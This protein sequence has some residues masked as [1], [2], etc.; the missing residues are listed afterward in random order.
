MDR[1]NS[2]GGAG[3]NNA[4]LDDSWDPQIIAEGGQPAASSGGGGGT[5]RHIT[6]TAGGD[7]PSA[8]QTAAA[9]AAL[10]AASGGP[11]APS[12][13]VGVEVS[14]THESK[15]DNSLLSVAT[16]SAEEAAAAEQAMKR[17]ARS[18]LLAC[19]DEASV[20]LREKM[21]CE[22][23]E[24]RQ[25]SPL[26]RSH[27]GDD[28]DVTSLTPSQKQKQQKQQQQI[29]GR[30]VNVGGQTAV[31][32]TKS[33]NP[34]STKGV[35]GIIE[36]SEEMADEPSPHSARKKQ[37]FFSQ[38]DVNDVKSGTED[39][40]DEQR[41]QSPG[42]TVGSRAAAVSD[43][44]S[45]FSYERQTQEEMPEDEF[46]ESVASPPQ[47]Q[48]SSPTGRR[49]DSSIEAEAA[50]REEEEEGIVA[51]MFKTMSDMCNVDGGSKTKAAAVGG[52]A[53]VGVG[54]AA[55]AA[56]STSKDRTTDESE[57]GLMTD[58]EGGLDV[59]ICSYLQNICGTPVAADDEA[60]PPPPPFMAAVSASSSRESYD[61]RAA[62][63]D[64]SPTRSA[65]Q[66][67]NTAIEVE[68]VDPDYYSS[69]EEDAGGA[70]RHRS[71]DDDA[72]R[73]APQEEAQGPRSW[74]GWQ[75]S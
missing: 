44:D 27:G 13:D 31:T 23:F 4:A 54:A 33:L 75:G 58:G 57:R 74:Q 63:L 37:A 17:Q 11:A 68:Y 32:S 9:A 29:G 55:V 61:R 25:P 39:E 24:E 52:A 10:S 18:P 8:A 26:K 16:G 65:D 53:T 1:N 35:R 45:Y 3:G 41:Q 71:A 48:P 19:V 60:P 56:G 6:S 50:K 46:N 28:S 70:G 42:V 15:N 67:E 69:D 38:L 36:E 43:D 47:S 73:A 20:M 30:V 66:Q 22:Y 72:D 21:N 64:L 62:E 12:A 34:P 7:R 5:T 51:G 40:A 59:D 2:R 14:P 49:I